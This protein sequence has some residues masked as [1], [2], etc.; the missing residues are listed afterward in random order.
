MVLWTKEVR[1]TPRQDVEAGGG[2]D[3]RSHPMEG[4][5]ARMVIKS[6]DSRLGSRL[7]KRSV[8]PV[9]QPTPG[10]AATQ[11]PA[12]AVNSWIVLG[13]SPKI[14]ERSSCR[15]APCRSPAWRPPGREIVTHNTFGAGEADVDCAI[16][17]NRDVPTGLR[18]GVAGCQIRG[19]CAIAAVVERM[20]GLRSNA[21]RRFL[22]QGGGATNS[23][24]CT[25]E[26]C[27]SRSWCPKAGTGNRSPRGRLD[28]LIGRRPAGSRKPVLPASP[29]F[30]RDSTE[31]PRAGEDSRSAGARQ[32]SASPRW[33][34]P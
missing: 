28:I 21:V 17:R 24:P 3:L 25:A 29:A 22:W 30:R 2:H 11:R 33:S 5:R 19:K 23:C 32:V 13:S 10:I 15:C 4:Y 14:A 16:E 9:L 34:P 31:R 20:W 26:R 27:A 12:L 7:G 1:R 18:T 8:S 6:Q